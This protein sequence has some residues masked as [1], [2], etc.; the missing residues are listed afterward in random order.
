MRKLLLV[1]AIV[2]SLFV[3][4]CGGGTPTTKLATTAAPSVGAF[5][6]R[7]IYV[8][9]TSYTESAVYAVSATSAACIPIQNTDTEGKVTL[10]VP[11]SSLSLN[12]SPAAS[13]T[14]VLDGRSLTR[15]GAIAA[16][17]QYWFSGANTAGVSQD[18]NI[19]FSLAGTYHVAGT[20]LSPETN[21]GLWVEASIIVVSQSDWDSMTKFDGEL[22]GY[23]PSSSMNISTSS[24]G[25]SGGYTSINSSVYTQ[26]SFIALAK[27][28]TGVSAGAYMAKVGQKLVGLGLIVPRNRG[29]GSEVPMAIERVDVKVLSSLGADVAGWESN[30][31]SNY[32][33]PTNCA[34][35]VVNV[36]GYYQVQIRIISNSGNKITTITKRLYVTSVVDTPITLAIKV[37]QPDGTLKAVSLYNNAL[38]VFNGVRFNIIATKPGWETAVQEIVIFNPIAGQPS[39]PLMVGNTFIQGLMSG[40]GTGTVRIML[41]RSTNLNDYVYKDITVNVIDGLGQVR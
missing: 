23:T 29:G 11:P 18:G 8:P 19:S 39:P 27:T 34:S 17:W 28:T 4:G 20:F 13:N 1:A 21:N 12:V 2:T 22:M 16:T 38:S 37:V 10:T 5:D 32:S 36:A 41:R 6:S 31:I 9:P 35:F 7:G 33:N 14:P 24:N 26:E 40:T 25:S 15:G 3:A 30:S